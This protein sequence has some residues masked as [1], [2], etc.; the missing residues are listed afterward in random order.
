MVNELKNHLDIFPGASNRT[1]C[2]NHIVNLI[3]KSVI[4]QFDT[5]KVKGNEAFDDVLQELMVSAEDLNR[6]GLDG[7]S[8][9]SD[10]GLSSETPTTSL[11]VVPFSTPNG[12]TLPFT[13]HSESFH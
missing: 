10:V 7:E 2:F 13:P 9:T 5:P 11:G 4:W 1:R 3:A 6:E 8:C 12:L